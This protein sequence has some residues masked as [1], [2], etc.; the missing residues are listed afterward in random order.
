MHH[1]Y[2]GCWDIN[3]S[4]PTESGASQEAGL[5]FSVWLNDSRCSSRQEHNRPWVGYSQA[6][7]S[8]T[9]QLGLI[10]P[11]PLEGGNVQ[12]PM[13]MPQDEDARQLIQM[14][15]SFLL[16]E[17]LITH[18]FKKSLSIPRPVHIHLEWALECCPKVP[19]TVSLFVMEW[20]PRTL[21]C[22]PAWPL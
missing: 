7:Q 3:W 17:T 16:D 10:Q 6:G 13:E 2:S 5:P 20:W 22:Y 15:G 12:G 14:L 11:R 18:F 9:K 21:F 4:W 19:F 1:P 8:W